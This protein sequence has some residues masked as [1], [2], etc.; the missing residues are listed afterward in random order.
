MSFY[1]DLH[2]MRVVTLWLSFAVYS[3][4]SQ[5]Y[6]SKKKPGSAGFNLYKTV[7]YIAFMIAF[8]KSEQETNVAPSIKRSK[9]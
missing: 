7:A 9:S 5:R 3:P 8:P 2:G 1:N 4:V 6:R